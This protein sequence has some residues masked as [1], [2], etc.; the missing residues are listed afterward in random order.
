[1][2][3]L[4]SPGTG[5]HLLDELG[6]INEGPEMASICRADEHQEGLF[7]LPAGRRSH[8]DGATADETVNGFHLIPSFW[9]LR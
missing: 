5:Y 8:V 7:G 6:I 3:Y 1:M 4:V 9:R 2:S